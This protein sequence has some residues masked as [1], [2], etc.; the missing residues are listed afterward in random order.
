MLG[1][2]PP[3]RKNSRELWNCCAVVSRLRG[4]VVNSGGIAHHRLPPTKRATAGLSNIQLVTKRGQFAANR[5][6]NELF[7]ADV[8]SLERSLRKT[9]GLESFLNREAI[10]RNAGDELSMS[11]RLIEA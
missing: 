1:L 7:D 4:A 5:F 10:I 8:A 6:G 11:L 9:A 2:V 3:G